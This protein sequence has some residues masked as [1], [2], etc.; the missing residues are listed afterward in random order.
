MFDG[1]SFSCAPDPHKLKLWVDRHFGSYE[2][3]TAYEAGCCGYSAQSSFESYGWQSL[4]VNPADISKTGKSQYQKTDKID[5]SLICRELKDGRLSSITVPDPEREALRCL[6][7]R[8]VELVGDFRRIKSTLKMQ[9]LYLGIEIP[10]G[11][12]QS[13]WSHQFRNWIRELKTVF[14]SSEYSI[15]SRLSQFEYIDAQI[16]EVSNELRAYC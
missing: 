12:D 5:A 13:S 10:E 15:L 8:R 9:L 7:R 4:V 6:F 1:K 2:V 3:Y 16:R 11:L 14:I